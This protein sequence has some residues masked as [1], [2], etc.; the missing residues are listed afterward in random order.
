MKSAAWQEVGV[1]NV[2]GASFIIGRFLSSLD[3]KGLC[4]TNA[5]PSP[6]FARR[7]VSGDKEFPPFAKRG[8]TAGF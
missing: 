1:V 6:M 2:M 4:Q 5:N 7:Q 8:V 3:P